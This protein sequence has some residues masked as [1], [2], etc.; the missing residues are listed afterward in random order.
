MGEFGRLLYHFLRQVVLVIS[1]RRVSI[2]KE[3][4]GYLDRLVV[5]ESV[6]LGVYG[7]EVGLVGLFE[8][9]LPLYCVFLLPSSLFI[10][11]KTEAESFLFTSEYIGLCLRLHQLA[12]YAELPIFLL[13]F[14]LL[15]GVKSVF[16]SLFGN[17]LEC[18]F[19]LIRLLDVLLHFEELLFLTL[20]WAYCPFLFGLF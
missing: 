9:L 16:L 19:V 20:F 4:G 11:H 7:V 6:G 8:P 1:N 2:H 15:K 12:L 18:L 5:R 13:S 10:V 14:R 3:D 17:L